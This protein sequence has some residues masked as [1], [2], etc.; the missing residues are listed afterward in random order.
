LDRFERPRLANILEWSRVDASILMCVLVLATMTVLIAGVYGVDPAER[1]LF[2]P[3]YFPILRTFLYV[4]VVP[5][6]LLLVYA[7]ATRR[8]RPDSAMVMHACGQMY[9]IDNTLLALAIGWD[10]SPWMAMT[11]IVGAVCGFLLFG[12]RTTLLAVASG[13]AVLFVGILAELMGWMPH[14]PVLRDSPLTGSDMVLWHLLVGFNMIW[15]TFAIVLTVLFVTSRFRAREQEVKEMNALLKHMFGR[16]LSREV[17]RTL[18]DNPDTALGLGGKRTEVTLLMSDLRGFTALAERLSPEETIALLNDYFEVMVEV[19]MRHNGMINEIIGD[20]LL[21]IFGAPSPTP[22][23]AERAVACALDMQLAMAVVN[24]K[25]RE[26]GRPVLEMGIGVNTGQVVVG[27]IGSRQRT[28]YGVVGRDVNLTGRIESYTTGG[29]VLI[30]ESVVEAVG[31]PITVDATFVVHPK[32]AAALTLSEVVGIGPPYDLALPTRDEELKPLETPIPVKWAVLDGKHLGE[33]RSLGDLVALSDT[34]GLL[35][36]DIGLEVLANVLFTLVD[37]PEAG[38]VYAKVVAVSAEG[39]TLRFT[40]LPPQV[41]E[42]F[43]VP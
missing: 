17:M 19:C 29:Q 15:V 13:Y 4:S 8:S 11:F 34:S 25:N 42:V 28:K 32:G 41:Q 35:R 16:Y 33:D 1:E 39:A 10:T 7:V 38:E 6:A 30:S 24:D 12:T 2:H 26:L 22:H 37:T 20:A 14:A 36:A 5:W 27:N 31:V 9:I 3:E 18:L 21:V 43:A 40:S 23:H